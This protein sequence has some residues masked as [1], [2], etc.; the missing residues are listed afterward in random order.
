MTPSTRCPP[1][2]SRGRLGLAALAVTLLLAAGDASAD[3]TL[4]MFRHGEKPDLGYGQLNCRGLN[5]ALALPDVLLAK[6]GTPAALYA[7]NPGVMTDDH[8]VPYNYIRPLA[9]I[10]PTAI[11]LGMPV[12]TQ[13]GLTST[14]ALSAELLSPAH[15]DQTLFVAWEHNLI[16]ALT[17][18][19]V[20]LR[21][22][23]PGGVPNWASDDFDSLWIVR[24]PAQGAATFA[25]DHQGLNGL[26]PSCPIVR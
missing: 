24:I 25:V 22:G 6:F 18:H 1:V 12:N 26:S 5:R 21:H 2:R 19:I 20:S 17:R 14:D 9:T 4:V 23:D 7:P 11:R 16:V 8:G 10:E 3:T 15:R 13:W